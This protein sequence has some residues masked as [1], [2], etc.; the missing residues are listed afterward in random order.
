MTISRVIS[1]DYEQA[2][3][4]GLVFVSLAQLI[5]ITTLLSVLDCTWVGLSISSIIFII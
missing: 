5:E 4:L 3:R 1:G 2:L